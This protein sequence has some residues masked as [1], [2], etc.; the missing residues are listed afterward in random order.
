MLIHAQALSCRV[1]VLP[2]SH[3]PVW[4]A[5]FPSRT[6]PSKVQDTGGSG[7]GREGEAQGREVGRRKVRHAQG[8]QMMW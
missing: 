8:V 7:K 4:E 3:G 5:R 6:H 2:E 1:L